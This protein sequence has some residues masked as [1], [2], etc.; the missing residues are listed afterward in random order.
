MA[1][2]KSKQVVRDLTTS[3]LHD[4]QLLVRHL[5]AVA[6]NMVE[7]RSNIGVDAELDYCQRVIDNK[8]GCTDHNALDYENKINQA[9]D[10]VTAGKRDDAI[11]VYIDLIIGQINKLFKVDP[12]P[13][14]DLPKREEDLVID[15]IEKVIEEQT[16]ARI[17]DSVLSYME[18]L[19]S[20]GVAVTQEQAVEALRQSGYQFA[21]TQEQIFEIA[22]E[23][24]GAATK[25]VRKRAV[26][27]AKRMERR[28]H[29]IIVETG[30][31]EELLKFLHD[32]ATYPYA[33]MR[34]GFDIPFTR[35]SWKGNKWVK[36]EQ[37]LPFAKRISPINFY[38]SS[39]SLEIDDGTAV[40]DVTYLRRAEL[41]KMWRF[42]K[43]DAVKSTLAEAI[44]MC[45]LYDKH[46]NWL[47]HMGHEKETECQE[48]S[49][50][51]P[52]GTTVPVFR[53]HLLI[54]ACKMR[55]LGMN[56]KGS[57]QQYE[58]EAWLL[59]DWIIRFNVYDPSGYRRPYNLDKFRY[60][61]GRFEGKSLAKILEPLEHEV[62]EVKRNELLNIGF[63][64]APIT[65]RD[66]SAFDDEDELPDIVSPGDNYDVNSKV[67]A[68]QKAIDFLTIPNITAQLR[69]VLF[70][71][72][73]EADIKSQI[74]SVLTGGGNLGS[75]VR[76]AS[77]LATQI[78]GASKNL[79]RQ[80]WLMA[81]NIIV[82]HIE[83]LF[84]YEML[85]GDD[86]RAKVDA[87]VTVGSIEALVNREFVLQNAQQLV[88]YL[89]PYAQ[90]GQISNEIINQLL[91]TVLSES[92]ISSGDDPE[93]IEEFNGLLN[94]SATELGTPQSQANGPALDGRSD[95]Q[96]LA[97]GSLRG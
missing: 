14:P 85:N 20:Q 55:E 40:G 50:M 64:S 86:D 46:R 74:P 26:T 73:A 88:Q 27:G 97:T 70:D 43:N 2:K 11:S 77:M 23:M 75:G 81:R 8:L 36:E 3:G 24:K 67:G 18:T 10:G 21:P 93:L 96:P 17:Q 82:P 66:V 89:S 76:S 80:M 54:D 78:G 45:N 79:K 69:Q 63:S 87:A 33:V 38:W 59:S 29:D 37:E 48:E 84:E 62:R 72:Q 9:I 19:T 47:E 31:G 39:D 92:G 41:E 51:W 65:L 60:L 91:F 5:R 44:Q 61:P 1:I 32:Y 28:I 30:F 83:T 16:N 68:N 35:K 34:D 25:V 6:Y 57:L 58:V 56:P 4:N 7:H 71:L 22:K 52:A 13:V 15:A 42:E 95:F 90:S 94:D 49:S 53:I 12:S